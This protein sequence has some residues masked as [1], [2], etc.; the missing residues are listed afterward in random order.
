[1]KVP[2]LLDASLSESLKALFPAGN[3]EKTTACGLSQSAEDMDVIN[4]A[5][6]KGA[7][8]VTTD[9]AIVSNPDF[10]FEPPV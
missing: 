8:L 4:L 1:M 6:R 10:H 7:V 9:Q 5:Q 2:F 3:V